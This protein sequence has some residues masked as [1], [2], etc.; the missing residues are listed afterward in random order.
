VGKTNIFF[1]DGKE[2]HGKKEYGIHNLPSRK[3]RYIS[4]IN[5][6]LQKTKQN[7]HVKINILFMLKTLRVRV[8]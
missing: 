8:P 6:T 4:K 2:E 1:F 5:I 3:E 7:I